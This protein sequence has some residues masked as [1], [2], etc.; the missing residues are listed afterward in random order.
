M[1]LLLPSH[2]QVSVSL[3]L[4]LSVLS[5][6]AGGKLLV[7]FVDGSPWFSVLEMLE[8]LKQKGHEIVVVAPEANINVKPSGNVTVKTYP[9][10][11]PQE[12]MDD[13]F[14]RFI[15]NSFE[16]GSFLERFFR[17]RENVKKGFDLSFLSCEQ[18]LHNEELIRYLEESN[19]DALFTDPVFLCG[20]ILAEHLS[21]PSVHFMIGIP[22]GLDFE[23][24]QCPSPPSYVPRL[25][26]DHTDHM[27]FLQ[28]VKNVIFDTSNLF[29]CDFLYKP[30]EKLASEFLQRDVT[31]LDLYRKASVWLL[32]YDFVL[33]YPRPLMPNMIAV[34]GVNCAHKQ[35][36][37]EFEAIVNASGEHGIV[38][39]SLGSMVSEIPMKKAM[40]IADALGSVPQTVLWRYTGEAPPNLPKNVK[41]VKWLPQ[42]DLL[43]HPKTRAFITH[44]GSHGIYEGI[45]NAVPMVLMPLFG[46]QMDNAK[47]VESRGAG[48]TLN[49]LEMTSKDISDALKAVIND[50][51]YKENIQRL[52]ELHLDR[53]IHPLD[54]AV[55][56]VEF[57]MRHKGAPHLR[58]AAHD[59]NWIQYHS[60]DVFAFLL[61]VVLL[62]LFISVK[63]CMF[64]CRRCCF[65]KGRKSKSGKSKTH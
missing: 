9:V 53:P 2:P 38:V 13:N 11:F 50:K 5:L 20:A 55:H 1:A 61:A 37:Q 57:V 64:C 34:G 16:E 59:L 33:E 29:L 65:K 4:L 10:P 43:A 12:E 60:L 45:C 22:C 48:L 26:S 8:I 17:L 63:C 39:F 56:W 3:L 40:E 25:F 49:I 6:A 52:S 7:V 58:P 21:I 19:F 23:A 30:Y 41:L 36:S 42:N 31:M 24:T 14:H 51:K 46:D 44:G 54:L 62:I 27:N 35:L 15:T 47:R 18:L 32:R 28:R